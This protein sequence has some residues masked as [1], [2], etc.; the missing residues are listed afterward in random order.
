MKRV[1][2]ALLTVVSLCTGCFKKDEGCKYKESTTVAPANE[3]IV[4]EEYLATNDITATKHSSGMYYEIVQLGS[5]GYPG[6]CSS[7]QINYVGKLTNGN[8]FDA[9]TNAVF[10]LGTLIDGWKKGLPLIQKSGRI[11]L[12]IPPSLGYGGVDI[13]DRDNNVIIPAN[14]MLIFYITQLNFQ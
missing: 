3:Q 4:I 11:K 10:A 1:V 2:V 6:L 8:T 5:G 12:Y 9:N 13:K 14:S 7:V